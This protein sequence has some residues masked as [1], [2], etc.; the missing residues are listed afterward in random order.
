MAMELDLPPRER[1]ARD[2]FPASPRG[3]RKWLAGIGA[4]EVREATRRFSE[5]V[6]ALNR[7]EIAPR[8]RLRIME[9]L[10]PSAREFLDHLAGRIQVQ[11][12]PL[13]ER[14]R[15]VFEFN[16]DLLRELA[17][18]Y[19]TVL[20]GDTEGSGPGPR[21]RIALAAERALSARGEVMLRSAQVYAPLPET[22]WRQVHAVHARAEAAGASD[23]PVRE[24]ELD[25]ARRARQSPAAMYR[26]LLLF[27]VAQTDG[28]RKA[29]S[30]RIYRALQEWADAATL[31][32]ADGAGL[33]EQG[34]E[35]RF[36]VDLAAPRGPLALRLH[37]GGDPASLRI[38]DV[39]GVLPVV[40]RLLAEA[41]SPEQRDA[42]DP[43]RISAVALQRLVDNW[44]QRAVRRSTR[45]V[46]GEPVE[47]EVTLP[48]IHGRLTEPPAPPE[49]AP[50]P[51]PGATDTA[52][53]TLQTIERESA[54]PDT[55]YVTHPGFADDGGAGEAWDRVGRG[56]AL[57]P[58]YTRARAE[59][60][61]EALEHKA[62]PDRPRWLLEDT[63][64]TGFRLRWAG[65]GSARAT[66]GEL[67]AV[68][69]GDGAGPGWRL[70]VIRWMQFVDESQFLVGCHALSTHA[71]GAAVRREPGNR[72]RR[73]RREQETSEP[74]LLLPGNRAR[75]VAATLVVPAHMFRSGEA[76][77]LDVRDRTL[78]VALARE[79]ENTG[80]F[81]RFEI[82]PAPRAAAGRGAERAARPSVW[83][84]L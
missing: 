3:V 16:L 56:T 32:P 60:E 40:E 22:F 55:G 23:R 24:P 43:D 58:G 75:G 27:A 4:L 65:E 31:R 13:P 6:R 5:G 78:R 10:R 21:R 84:S 42:V 66:V 14:S 26:R 41:E 64:Q 63:S 35:C 15:R 19:E 76:V 17:L 36:A 44:R 39:S 51:K 1:P 25:A 77:E 30:E 8:Q 50:E 82:A 20:A 18:G 12:L 29:E 52:S 46:H 53:L 83:E 9:L 57:A 79:H 7:L 48:H 11:S 61:R 37:P 49:P 38:L 73:R 47:V 59:A 54:R 74:A 34:A 33:D 71:S 67:V 81:T 45:A 72:N 80:A 62:H 68:R 70:G 69:L 28:L 2:G